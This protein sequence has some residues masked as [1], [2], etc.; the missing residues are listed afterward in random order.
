MTPADIM[1]VSAVAGPPLVGAF[2][3]YLTNKIAIKMLFRPLRP[4]FVFGIRIPMTPGVI[5]SKRHLLAQNIGS[6]VGEHLLT[7]KEIGT[8]VSREPFQVHLKNMV[9]GRIIAILQKDLGPISSFIPSSFMTCYKEAVMV[10]KKKAGDGLHQFFTSEHGEKI[11]YSFVL[12]YMRTMD[13]KTI[14]E[15]ITQDSRKSLYSFFDLLLKKCISSQK[16]QRYLVIS[17]KQTLSSPQVKTKKIK[18]IIPNALVSA[19][20]EK[21]RRATPEMLAQLGEKIQEQALR[22]SIVQGLK[23]GVDQL[24]DSIGPVGAMARGFI[25]MESIGPMLN[26][27]LAKNRKEIIHW[28]QRPVVVEQ[29]SSVISSNIDN[30]LERTLEEV[31]E[32]FDDRQ[33]ESTG[34]VLVEQVITALLEQQEKSEETIPGA[35]I[36][37]WL[38][39]GDAT[40]SSLITSLKSAEKTDHFE[41]LFAEK[42]VTLMQSKYMKELLQL[43]VSKALDLVLERPVGR[44]YDVIPAAIQQ[45][46]VQFVVQK[47]NT[48]LLKEVPGL[49]SSLKIE[50]LVTEKVDSLDLL[51]LEELLLSIMEEQFKYINLFGALLGFV[52]GCVNLLVL[53]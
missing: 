28:L 9:Q 32:H 6:M 18:E 16:V 21:I 17:I 46:G 49:V 44:M 38:Q 34:T 43:F 7:N 36:E 23:K 19:I 3:G 2:I 35:F 27:H 40:L 24:L 33:V 37:K 5:P 20:H 30:M 10:L 45:E 1:A 53:K 50:G 12:E 8:A 52:I 48:M 22:D 4:W 29:F 11:V 14:N 41:E 47:A 25:D 15:L 39:Q 42:I 13:E 51:R 31:L 26:E